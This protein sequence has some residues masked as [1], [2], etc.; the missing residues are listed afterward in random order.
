M[1][2]PLEKL[3][4]AGFTPLSKE[5]SLEV[6]GG[7]AEAGTSSPTF[8]GYTLVGPSTVWPDHVID[9]ETAPAQPAQTVT[10]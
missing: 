2:T 7:L 3:R 4:E 8:I 1:S 10:A 5:E 9:S 6:L